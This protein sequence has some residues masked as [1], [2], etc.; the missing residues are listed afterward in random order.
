MI[1]PV[2][3]RIDLEGLY[4]CKNNPRI[5]HINPT[6]VFGKFRIFS[7][8]SKFIRSKMSNGQALR[9]RYLSISEFGKVGKAGS[10]RKHASSAVVTTPLDNSSV[11]VL[12]LYRKNN[13]SSIVLQPF[14]RKQNQATCGYLLVQ[15]SYNRVPWRMFVSVNFPAAARQA[16]NGFQLVRVY[17]TSPCVDIPF[18][19]VTQKGRN[20]F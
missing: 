17:C 18:F 19:W 16:I 15:A 10:F 6:I 20:I 8:L 2:I 11:Q 12:I 1:Y 3:D 13:Q 7:K 9:G 14:L 5:V 4:N